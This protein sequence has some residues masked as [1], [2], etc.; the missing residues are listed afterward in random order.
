MI[1]L[2][3][4]KLVMQIAELGAEPQSLRSKETGCEYIW[5]GDPEYWFRHAPLLFPMTGPT[6]DDKVSYQC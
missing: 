1:T 6:K 2:H 4:D 5:N 3:N